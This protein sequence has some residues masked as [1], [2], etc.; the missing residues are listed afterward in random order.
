MKGETFLLTEY[1]EGLDIRYADRE[2][3]IKCLDALIYLQEKFWNYN[4]AAGLSFEVALES[5]INRGKYLGDSDIERIY[6]EYIS[7]Y[8]QLPRTLCHDD[9]LPFNLI[10]AEKD[11]YLIDWEYGGILPYPSSIARLIS[12][13]EEDENA[14]FFMKDEDK[15]FALDYYYNQFIM[16]KKISREEYDRII[17]LFILYEYCEWIMLGN[18][19]STADMTRYK[20]YLE[21]AR[22]H[23]DKM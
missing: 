20:I 1:V 13:C 10:V 19:Y 16:H 23:I 15:Q 14:F 5:R 21:K 3:I 12:H 9:L 18:K 6:S 11:A 22:R 17:D 2:K 4:E 8:Q 7:I